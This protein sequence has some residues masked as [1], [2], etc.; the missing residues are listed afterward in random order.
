MEFDFSPILDNWRFLLGGL[1][2]TVA[3]SLITVGASLVLGAAIG[4]ARVYGPDWLR[5]PLAFYIDSMR[6][7]PVLVVLVWMFFAVP[8]LI[9][10]SFP[11]FWAAAAAADGPHRRL[12]RGDRARRHRVRAAGADA[13]RAGARH[14]G[15]AGR[16]QDHPAAGRRAHAAVFG[17]IVSITIKDT[18]IATVIAVP[19]LMQQLARSLARADLPSDR[20]L[21]VRDA[22][23][24]HHPV[25]DHA[26]ASIVA[27]PRV[28]HLGRS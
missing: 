9:G 28:A 15:R 10:V 22:G 16:A 4:L 20:D 11:P 2:V 21:H 8:I 24:L 18:A 26:R 6:A 7:I 19:E 13:G 1:G 14:V 23:L 5:W 27:L 25:P 3:L 17:S 12:C